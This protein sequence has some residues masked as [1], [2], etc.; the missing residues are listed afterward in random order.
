MCG[1][2]VDWYRR[3]DEAGKKPKAGAL[4]LV[5]RELGGRFGEASAICWPESER[6]R[7]KRFCGHSATVAH[8]ASNVDVTGSNPV[9][10]S[11]Y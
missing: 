2:L 11:S 3:Y 4:E 1:F 6:D 7:C 5:Y 9:G 8:H 10:R